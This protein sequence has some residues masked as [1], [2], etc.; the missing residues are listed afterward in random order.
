MKQFTSLAMENNNGSV[1]SPS[2][3]LITRNPAQ[4]GMV[5]VSVSMFPV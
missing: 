1:K 4:L 5:P 3:T 2:M